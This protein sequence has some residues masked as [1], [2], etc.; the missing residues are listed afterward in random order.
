VLIVSQTK[1]QASFQPAPDIPRLTAQ[2]AKGDE[3]AYRQ[4]YDLYFSRLLRYLLVVTGNEDSAREALQLTL[5][6][7]A[8]HARRFESEPAFWGWLTVLAK[9][10]VTDEGRRSRRYL[11]F[12]GRFFEQKQ[13]EIAG[14]EDL[15]GDRLLA[16]LEK[17]LAALPLAERELLERKYFDHESVHDLAEQMRLTAKAVDSRLVRIRR[18]LKDMI[19]EEIRREK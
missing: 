2:M 10:C 15:A 5:L 6:R 14:A 4:F 1:L 18:R 3:G 12:L 7:V 8:K 16:L 19:L 13:T 17:N 11:S 9:S